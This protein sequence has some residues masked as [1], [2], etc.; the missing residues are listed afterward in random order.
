MIHSTVPSGFT[1]KGGSAFAM[2]GNT[3]QQQLTGD[4]DISRNIRAAGGLDSYLN[5][6]RQSLSDSS[7]LWLTEES[8]FSATNRGQESEFDMATSSVITPSMMR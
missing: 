5:D 7:V 8:N 4:V 1:N 3:P 6:L 2:T